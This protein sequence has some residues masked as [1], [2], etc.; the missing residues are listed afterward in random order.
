[1]ADAGDAVDVVVG[2]GGADLGR[3]GRGQGAWTKI[4]LV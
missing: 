4:R 3:L 2:G 1:M